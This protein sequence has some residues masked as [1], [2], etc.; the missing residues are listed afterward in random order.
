MT[1]TDRVVACSPEYLVLE[2]G[3]QAIQHAARCWR[4]PKASHFLTSTEAFIPI[5]DHDDRWIPG[6]NRMSKRAGRFDERLDWFRL[7]LSSARF[8]QC[9]LGRAN[10]V[11]SMNVRS[12]C[13]IGALDGVVHQEHRRSRCSHC[14]PVL[15]GYC[16][17]HGGSTLRQFRQVEIIL[18]SFS[19]PVA[20]ALISR[21]SLVPLD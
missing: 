18:D 13:V 16:A 3:R 12:G 21:S 14:R 1:M 11:P 7:Q 15:S 17:C 20:A 2:F 10:W 19:N 9:F 8:P 4:Q 5:A 6:S